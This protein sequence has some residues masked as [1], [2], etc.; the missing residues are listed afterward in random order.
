MFIIV[1]KELDFTKVK[2]KDFNL[3]L[4]K[5][6]AVVHLQTDIHKSSVEMRVSYE[7]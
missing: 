7:I 2:V 5:F 4:S 3:L 6:V 1:I